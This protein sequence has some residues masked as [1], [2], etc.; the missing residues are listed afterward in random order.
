MINE[1]TVY[2]GRDNT[3]EMALLKDGASIDCTLLT[4]CMVLAEDK[5]L[6]TV[7]TLDSQTHPEWF[8][9]S[10]KDKLIMKFGQAGLAAGRYAATLI[11]Y[12]AG[13]TNGIVWEDFV[14]LVKTA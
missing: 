12:D 7:T 9:R 3:I 10:N 11:V 4:R 6:N 8:D 5:V 2:I 14:M 1:Q 13:R